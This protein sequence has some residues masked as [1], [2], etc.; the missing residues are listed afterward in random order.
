MR[1]DKDHARHH[2]KPARRLPL[3]LLCLGALG[4]L[5]V[6]TGAIAAI[7]FVG[8]EFMAKPPG[9]KSVPLPP[10]TPPTGRDGPAL[11]VGR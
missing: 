1:D 5:A 10:A 7:G 9:D 6:I 2:G 8:A 4:L 3:W 11:P